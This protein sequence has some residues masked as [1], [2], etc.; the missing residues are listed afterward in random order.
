[1]NTL[2]CYYF[3]WG[4]IN[5]VTSAVEILNSAINVSKNTHAFDTL[6]RILFEIRTRAPVISDKHHPTFR[7]RSGFQI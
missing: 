4:G 6:Q 1:M 5:L 2:D 3:C 7:P